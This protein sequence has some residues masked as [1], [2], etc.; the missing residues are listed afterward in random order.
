MIHQLLRSQFLDISVRMIEFRSILPSKKPSRKRA[1]RKRR[2]R[3]V[4][5]RKRRRRR[6]MTKV[7]RKSFQCH[8]LRSSL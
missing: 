1:P 3:E 6:M 5:R 2:R 8:W 7:R 4:K